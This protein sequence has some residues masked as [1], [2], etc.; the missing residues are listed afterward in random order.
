MF[1]WHKLKL[2]FSCHWIYFQKHIQVYTEPASFF[3]W[4]NSTSRFSH[5]NISF[6]RFF[7][8]LTQGNWLKQT[9][10]FST[11]ICIYRANLKSSNFLLQRAPNPQVRHQTTTRLPLFPEYFNDQL[12]WRLYKCKLL[13]LVLETQNL[14]KI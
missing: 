4:R 2:L 13:N 7:Y 9:L 1:F 10:P 12:R 6:T 8:S 5:I 3:T 14:T 11:I